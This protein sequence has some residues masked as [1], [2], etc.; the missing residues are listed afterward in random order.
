MTITDS[1]KAMPTIADALLKYFCY[2]HENRVWRA[3][4]SLEEAEF[5]SLKSSE[6]VDRAAVLALL[7]AKAEEWRTKAEWLDDGSGV[8]SCAEAAADYRRRAA[9]LAGERLSGRGMKRSGR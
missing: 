1:I 4:I 2:D 7:E 9:E 8:T 5:Q 6:A 3:D